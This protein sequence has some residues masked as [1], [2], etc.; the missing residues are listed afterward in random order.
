MV[1]KQKNVLVLQGGGALGSYQAGVYSVL[2][3][4]G[5]EPDWLAGIS[6]GA[7]NAAIIAGNAFEDRVKK[8][9]E[10]WHLITSVPEMPFIGTDNLS[11]II[12][13]EINAFITTSVGTPGFFK[14]HS[15]MGIFNPLMSISQEKLSYYDTSPLKETLLKLVD[16]DRINSGNMRLSVGAVHVKTGNFVYFDSENTVIR[17]EHIM[18]SGALPEG[19]PPVEIDG[20][21]YWDGGLVSNTPLQYV[22]D[23]ERQAHMRIHQIDLFNAQGDMPQNIF[24]V[25]Q[26]MKDIRFSSRTRLHTDIYKEKLQIQHLLS[27]IIDKIPSDLLDTSDMEMLKTWSTQRS[28]NI[29][30]LIY[31]SKKYETASKDYEFSHLSMDEHWRC[32]LNDATRMLDHKDWQQCPEKSKE[33]IHIFDFSKAA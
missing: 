8:L 30:Q 20:E 28:I 24:D 14:P 17:P 11:R 21:F 23:A 5:Y 26:R 29:I 1:H 6:I 13:N 15:L 4:H 2:H 32:G 19:L 31:R 3:D 16:F 10:F 33:G 12:H 18:A 27:R 7:I 9:Y 25:Q 22:I